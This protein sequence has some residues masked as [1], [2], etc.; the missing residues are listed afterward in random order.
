M[1]ICGSDCC[2]PHVFQTR[3][4]VL[5]C[6]SHTLQLLSDQFN[7]ERLGLLVSSLAWLQVRPSPQWMAAVCDASE[8][9]MARSQPYS[10]KV[11]EG[12]AVCVAACCM[13]PR[14]LHLCVKH[15]QQQLRH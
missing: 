15:Q 2:S 12:Q 5:L 8:R 7:D 14:F 13:L 10:S 4:S 6:L 3:L 1:N 11:C 9:L